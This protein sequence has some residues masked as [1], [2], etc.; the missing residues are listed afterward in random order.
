M[1]SGRETPVEVPDLAGERWMQAYVRCPDGPFQIVAVDASAR[2]W[3]AFRSPVT[4]PLGS[5]LAQ[6][7]IA[8]SRTLLIV[9]IALAVIAVRL[10]P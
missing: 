2:Y 6:Q 4:V 10:P 9:A 7:L 3:F 1:E 5:M 8:A